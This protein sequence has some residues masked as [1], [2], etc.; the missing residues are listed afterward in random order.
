MSIFR[1]R[2]YIVD[3]IRTTGK[4]DNR[5]VQKKTKIPT[6]DKTKY[7]IC[8]RCSKKGYVRSKGFCK[9]CKYR[10]TPNKRLTYEKFTLNS[11]K[12]NTH[13]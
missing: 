5:V 1:K 4:K 8:P 12:N 6:Q 13:T 11:K 9:L 3:T 10:F 2:D 7:S